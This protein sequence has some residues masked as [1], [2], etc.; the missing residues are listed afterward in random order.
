MDS[1]M[2]KRVLFDPHHE[3]DCNSLVSETDGHVELFFVGFKLQDYLNNTTV[4]DQQLFMRK[5]ESLFERYKSIS[6]T[7]HINPAEGIKLIENIR[8]GTINSASEFAR[9]L[10]PHPFLRDAFL[11]LYP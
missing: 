11:K 7:Y 1:D 9:K 10:T 4:F 3:S 5:A 8:V 6:P 2:K